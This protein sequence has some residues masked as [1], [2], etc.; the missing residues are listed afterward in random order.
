LPTIT[1][2]GKDDYLLLGE[3]PI[4]VSHTRGA[5]MVRAD[6]GFCLEG[7]G[8]GGGGGGVRVGG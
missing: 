1:R 5:K 6:G 7:A 3:K 4:S 2:E 8:R